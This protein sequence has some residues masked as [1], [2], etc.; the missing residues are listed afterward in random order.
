MLPTNLM[1]WTNLWQIFFVAYILLY[2][3][4]KLFFNFEIICM[5]HCLVMEE[6][7]HSCNTGQVIANPTPINFNSG[8]PSLVDFRSWKACMSVKNL[9]ILLYNKPI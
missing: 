6:L 5:L 9:G 1:V 2:P 8:F 3:M 4:Y 7:S